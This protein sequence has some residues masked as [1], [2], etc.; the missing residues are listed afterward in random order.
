[1][2]VL[3]QNAVGE[4]E[5]VI[6]SASAAHCVLVEH[7][8]SGHCFSR[9]EDVSLGAFDR[10]H[11]FAR[12]RGDA[13][14]A[15]HEIQDHTLAGE[16]HAR[17]VADDSGGLPGMHAHTIENFWMADDVVV[18]DHGAVERGV[19]IENAIDAA[20]AGQDAI[21]LNQKTGAAPADWRPM[22]A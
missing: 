16:N 14:H 19:D 10:V 17:I 20:D 18:R 6:L 12:H 21:L 11:E 2:I 8:Q 15:L 1:M 3:H 13:A 4:I 7:T 22:Q 9:V 5:T